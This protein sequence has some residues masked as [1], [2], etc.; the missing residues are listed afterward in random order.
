MIEKPPTKGARLRKLAAM[1]ASVAGGYATGRVKRLFLSEEAAERDRRLGLQAAGARIVETLGELKGAAMKVGQMASMAADLLPEELKA[2]LQALQRHAPPMPYEVIAETIESEFDQPVE[3]LFDSFVRTPFAAASIGQVH[4][5]VVDGCHVI[6]KVQYP[7]VDQAVDSDLRHLRLALSASGLV[8][9]ERRALAASFQAVRER[10]HEELDYCNESDNVRRF[11]AFHA[12]HPFVVV[13]Q[14][15]GHR[16]SK[17]VLTLTYE[18][19]D[20]LSDLDALGYTQEERNRCGAHLWR[21]LQSQIFELHCIHADPNPANFAFRKDGTVVLYD[22]GCVQALPE[23]LTDALKT[24]AL[25]GL[26][27]DYDGVEAGLVALGVRNLAGARPAD[28]FYKLWRDWLA[29]PL[30]S[31]AM[32]DFGGASF[33]R[34]V[35]PELLPASLRYVSSFQP[36]GDMVFLNRMFV[37]L[38]AI[39]RKMRAR[40]VIGDELERHAPEVA[41][42]FPRGA[43]ALSA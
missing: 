8:P 34:A 37:G 26:R 1:T 4:R 40:I 35:F 16:S 18:A 13:P 9:I 2:P 31:Q 17:R 11:H 23:R 21:T 28:D 7:G 27:E 24:T 10:L 36:S 32:F 22:F 12:G 33:E 15:V 6:V 41:A 43:A 3:A 20:A 30:L 5:A 29:R 19:G 39:L 14:V 42:W 38:Y 25:A